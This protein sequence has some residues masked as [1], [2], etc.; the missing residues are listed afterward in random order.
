MLPSFGAPSAPQLKTPTA[1]TKRET[2]DPALAV[3]AGGRTRNWKAVA[4][5]SVAALALPL[6]LY[7]AGAFD[8]DVQAVDAR[9]AAAVDAGFAVSRAADAGAAAVAAAAA[10]DAGSNDSATSDAGPDDGGSEV[11]ATVD[12][13]PRKKPRIKKPPPEVVPD[14]Y[15]R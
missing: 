14:I 7:A 12:A 2:D 5:G 8:R 11:A 10:P 9:P 1:E 15:S 3:D 4:L 13:G 6:G